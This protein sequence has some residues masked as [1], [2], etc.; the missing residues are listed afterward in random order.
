MLPLTDTLL[1]GVAEL[2][3]RY[4]TAPAGGR[5]AVAVSGGADSVVLLH[6]LHRLAA[7]F[8]IALEVIHINHH[9]RGAESSDDQQFVQE[10]TESLGLNLYL[11]Q[12]PVAVETG[13][14]EQVARDAR[15]RVFH[16][17]VESGRANYVATGHTRSDQAETVL[18][19]LLR[20]SGV[21]GLA[22]MRIV[23]N[24]GIVRPLLT[25]SRQEVRAWAA[26]QRLRWREDS[27]NSDPR[28]SR[29]LLR[30]EVLPLVQSRI[31]PGVEGVLAGVADLAQAEEDYWQQL[32]EPHFQRFA[33]RSHFGLLCD[34][35]YLQKQ[36]LA[37]RRRLLRRALSDVKGN[38]R[39]V[40]SSHVEAVARVCES[41]Q[42]HDRVM[43][44]GVDA[45]RS[46][47]TLRLV[48]PQGP[49]EQ[50]R[51]YKVPLQ[52]GRE[53][54]LPFHAGRIQLELLGGDLP[55]Q[56]VNCVNF[57]DGQDLLETA[58]ELARLNLDALGGVP[59]IG[60]LIVRNWEPGD[61][62]QRVGHQSREKLKTLFQEAKVL[63]WERRH[64]PVLELDGEVVW[65]RRFGAAAHAAAE[66]GTL[67]AVSIR[68][69]V[70]RESEVQFLTSY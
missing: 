13:N 14:I 60:R 9:L 50:K 56:P 35:Y 47:G 24:D 45:L 22:G 46:F 34:I 32:I 37:I 65:A 25:T 58:V 2:M 51:H 18:F 42:G 44:P 43:I 53:I 19:R 5:I 29:N 55:S 66:P 39:S 20:G 12:A 57:K 27:S 30:N 48:K 28:F 16:S 10:L 41:D 38:L 62:I 61:G 36:P 8:Q 40:D 52:L 70:C 1:D 67:P 4:N 23:T 15:R 11:T 59:S 68:Y 33:K 6:V 17:F 31:N 3:T 7:R 69:R 64:W 21:A 54:A 63:L 26:A 49:E